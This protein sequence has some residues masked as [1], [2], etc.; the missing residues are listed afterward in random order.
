MPDIELPVDHTAP[1]DVNFVSRSPHVV[2]YR[3]WREESDGSW[4]TLG[5]GHTADHEPDLVTVA[6]APAGTRLA[7]WLGIGGN[8]NTQYQGLVTLAQNGKIVTGGSLLESGRV[9][10]NGVAEAREFIELT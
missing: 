8:P 5:Q 1:I 7:F 2:A 3:L 4:T 6:P 9:D 10:G